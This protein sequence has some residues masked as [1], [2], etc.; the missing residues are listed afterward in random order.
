M[1]CNCKQRPRRSTQSDY[2]DHDL[3]HA[4]AVCQ[5]CV[6]TR[7]AQQHEFV[8]AAFVALLQIAEEGTHKPVTLLKNAHDDT[9]RSMEGTIQGQ[10][11]ICQK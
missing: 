2:L 3:T 9:E 4:F 6:C 7:L 10:V 5:W 8:T 1:F 11:C